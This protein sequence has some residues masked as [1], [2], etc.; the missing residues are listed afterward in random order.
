MTAFLYQYA[1]KFNW[2]P[3]K[4]PLT[5]H[6]AIAQVNTPFAN[7]EG[8]GKGRGDYTSGVEVHGMRGLSAAK[9]SC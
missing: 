3:K 1:R 9:D 6:M 7:R 2:L 8:Q 5:H 4:K